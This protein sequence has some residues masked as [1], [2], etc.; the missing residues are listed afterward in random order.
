MISTL[1]T[2]D[3]N[4]A[5]GVLGSTPSDTNVSFSGVNTDSRKLQ[6]GEL[7]V[8]L[9]GDNFDGHAYLQQAQDKGAVAAI[10]SERVATI[11]MPQLEVEDTRLALG[12]LAKARR[13][14]FNGKVVGLTGSNGKT[15][16][17]ELIAAILRRSGTTLATEGNFNNDI[18]MPLTL[19]KLR[20]DEKFA[21]IEM[22]ANHPGEIAYLTNISQPDVAV[23]TNAGAA[24]LEGFKSI[25]GVAKAKGEIFSGVKAGGFAIINADDRYCDYWLSITSHLKVL[26]FSINSQPAD[27]YATEIIEHQFVLVTPHGKVKVNFPLYGKHNVANA[28]AASAVATALDIDL[29]T[30]RRALEGISPVKGRLNFLKGM[31]DVTVIDD[32]YNANL[33]STCAAINVL[34]KLEGRKILVFGDMLEAGDDATSMHRQVGQLA[35]EKGVDRL[36]A[37]G[38]MSRE[39]VEVFGQGAEFFT[40]KPQLIE[41]LKAELHAND[42]IL[43]KGSRGMRL[44][45]VVNSLKD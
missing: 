44:E 35:R 43:V 9:K 33:D 26:K 4:T 32:C 24:H 37:F 27:V 28:V 30:I 18:G 2:Y 11:Q 22:G 1:E 23:I 8:A 45:D 39:A 41:A 7:F 40:E 6:A 25:E 31:N 19:L 12:V 29:M 14:A 17:K 21:V 34:A 38:D 3:L 13:N 36:F 42:K 20:N 10:V 16:V 15:T 5:A